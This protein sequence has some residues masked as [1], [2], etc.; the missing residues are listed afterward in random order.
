MIKFQGLIHFSK[1]NINYTLEL[2]CDD[3]ELLIIDLKND[4][5][6]YTWDLT[7]YDMLEQ[8]LDIIKLLNYIDEFI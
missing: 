7:D 5:D 3:E 2:K 6:D 4:N 8:E 1:N